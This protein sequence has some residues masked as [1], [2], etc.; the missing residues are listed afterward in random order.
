[1]AASV[2]VQFL[3]IGAVSVIWGAGFLFVYNWIKR[4]EARDPEEATG[5]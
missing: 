4:S 2:P 1:M 3:F 5:L